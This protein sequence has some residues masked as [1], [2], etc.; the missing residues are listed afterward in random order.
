[1][2]D[3]PALRMEDDRYYYTPGAE[4]MTFSP[5]RSYCDHLTEDYEKPNGEWNTIEV[6]SVNGNSLHLVNG[7]VNNR[8]YNARHIVDGV[9]VPLTKGKIQLQSEGAEIFYRDV[10]IRQ[11][12]T[13]PEDLM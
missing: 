12:D 4:L 2:V 6:Y 8:V 7:N 5:E 10:Q 13:I 3:I 1:M 11:I 9:E